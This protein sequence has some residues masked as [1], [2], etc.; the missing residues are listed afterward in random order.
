[1]ILAILAS[2]SGKRL[3]LKI[4]K[5]L[6]KINNQTLLEKIISQNSLFKKIYIV[7]GYKF[8]LIKN[9]IKNKKIKKIFIIKNNLYKKTNMVESFFKL[10]KYLD[11]DVIISYGDILYD[12]KI[13]NKMKK[14]NHSHVPLNADWL[15]IW[16]KRM[17]IKKILQDAEDVKVNQDNVTSIGKKITTKLPKFQFMGLIKFKKKDLNKIFK[18]YIKLK[19]KKIDFTSFLNLMIEEKIIKLKFFPTKNL[20][21]EIDT[22]KDLAEAKKYFI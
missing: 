13:L 22:P 7:S 21:F 8:K 14:F 17:T 5:C 19:N 10:K 6:V 12:G 2:G 16:K 18:F 1:M 9:E 15:K 4:P 11:D 20:W 3:N